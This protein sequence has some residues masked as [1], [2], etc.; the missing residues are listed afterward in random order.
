MHGSLTTY[1][2][3][4]ER[5]GTR[6]R[7]KIGNNTYLERRDAETIAVKLH[8][9]DV[10]TFHA[11]GT[12][13]LDSGGY[14]TV[15]TK[16]RLNSYAPCP[17]IFSHRGRWFVG[18]K[19]GDRSLPYFDGITFT[20]YGECVNPQDAPDTDAQDAVNRTL[21]ASIASY[22]GLY[23][24]DRIAELL[25]EAQDGGHRGDCLY[26]QLRDDDGNPPNMG[27][28]HLLSHLE[29]GYTMVSLAYNA[30]RAAG[31]RDP[32]FI[33]HAAPELTRAAIG[34]FLRK[35]LLSGVE[36]TR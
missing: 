32:V 35:S 8:A 10:V 34:K 6:D 21:R 22:V 9:T 18:K 4:A 26:C 25:A 33:L 29:E 14:L 36:V 30:V 19:D 3:A 7:R 13:T 16:D 1:S 23:T 28:D 2:Q 15:T 24:D 11:N 27:T 5:L 17:R 20:D 31:Y 12:A